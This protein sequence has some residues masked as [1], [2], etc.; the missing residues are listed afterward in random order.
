MATP[1]R[2][3]LNS[4]ATL[5]AL[6][7]E[8]EELERQLAGRDADEIVREHTE[9]LHAYHEVKEGAQTLISRV[10]ESRQQTMADVYQEIGLD[11]DD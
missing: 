10:A 9:L 4:E 11:L 5:A 2:G 6:R 1:R 3:P 7:E 8:V